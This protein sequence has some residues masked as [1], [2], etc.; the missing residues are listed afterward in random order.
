M[1]N[2]EWPMAE[3]GTYAISRSR[4]ECAL[5]RAEARAPE[6]VIE[7]HVISSLGVGHS[8]AIRHSSFVI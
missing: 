2:G 3:R 6:C 5:K 1:A 7:R 4:C 8:F